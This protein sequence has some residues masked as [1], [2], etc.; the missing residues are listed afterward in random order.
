MPVL[1]NPRDVTATSNIF[2]DVGRDINITNN[3]NNYHAQQPGMFSLATYCP[4]DINDFAHAWPPVLDYLSQSDS[5]IFAEELLLKKHGYPLW[6]PDPRSWGDDI[7]QEYIFSGVRIGDVRVV[8][9][10]GSFD[11]IF[12]IYSLASDPMNCKGVPDDFSPLAWPESDIHSQSLKHGLD[13]VISSPGILR[14][15]IPPNKSQ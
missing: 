7:P 3:I 2:N 9:N 13:T 15:A 12:N 8:K 5:E 11:C 10:D 14:Q 1:C 6:K 4:A